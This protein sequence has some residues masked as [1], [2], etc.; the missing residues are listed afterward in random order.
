MSNDWGKWLPFA[1]FT[2]NTT[3]HS[4]TKYTPYEVL[5][6]RIANILGKLRRQPQPLY[7]FDDT[8]LDI[9]QKKKKTV[10]KLT[11]GD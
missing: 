2:Y 6:G 11:E 7:Y 5:F 1:C 4:V 8:G 9:R 10:S 3:P